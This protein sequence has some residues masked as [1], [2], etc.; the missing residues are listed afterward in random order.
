MW[1]IEL[2][3]LRNRRID[4]RCG[5]RQHCRS[6]YRGRE[7]GGCAST[8]VIPAR[9]PVTEP[10]KKA[11]PAGAKFVYLQSSDPIGAQL[12]ALLEPAVKAIGAKYIAINAGETA[13]SAQAAASS[14][15]ADKP[16]V[17]FVP[18]F[19]PSEFGGKLRALSAEGAKIVGTAQVGWQKYGIDWC[20]GCDAQMTLSGKLLADWVVATKGA[21]A[22]AAFYSVPEFGFTAEMYASFKAQMT[23]LCP[24]CTIRNVPID[25]ST[26]GSTAP[27]TMINDLQSHP[28][29]NVAVFSSMDM[30]QGMPAAMQSAG[31][32]VATIGNAPTPENL[33]DIKAGKLDAGVASDLDI[34]CWTLV[35]VGARLVIGQTPQASEVFAPTQVLTQKDITFDTQYGYSAYP[36]FAKRFTA[37]WHPKG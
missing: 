21:K 30:A 12:G 16:S 8:P 9:F 27:Q 31:V 10:L 14:A 33:D 37:L 2:I 34:L 1:L 5:P 22:N 13:S 25:V 19:P 23:T 6:Q 26:I 35:D 17:V 28:S 4:E 24:S 36:D 15:L 20:T 29:T 7:G 18:A 32:N 3:K 11:L